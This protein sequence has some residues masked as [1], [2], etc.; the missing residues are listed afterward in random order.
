MSRLD[1]SY[2]SSGTM[3][4][5]SPPAYSAQS[6]SL[7]WWLAWAYRGYEAGSISHGV[8]RRQDC[9]DPL[10]QDLL[11]GMTDGRSVW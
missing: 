8:I 9:F 2:G 6:I 7:A 4:S 10:S 3:S 11:A 1:D 5:S